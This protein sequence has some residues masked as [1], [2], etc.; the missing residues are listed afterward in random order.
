MI[1][2]LVARVYPYRAIFAVQSDAKGEDMYTVT[3]LASFI[4]H[5]GL[6]RCVYMCD[7]ETPIGAMMEAALK[8]VG[9]TSK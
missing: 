4:R 2:V 8:I 3:R 5:C 7:Q 6:E 9:K 1:T